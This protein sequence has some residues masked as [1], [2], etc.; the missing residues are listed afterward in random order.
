[1]IS[2]PKGKVEN[3]AKKDR[4]RATQLVLVPKEHIIRSRQRIDLMRS[5]R[6]ENT[7]VVAELYG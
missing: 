4:E 5:T 1:M 7:Y 6:R 3:R 2:M